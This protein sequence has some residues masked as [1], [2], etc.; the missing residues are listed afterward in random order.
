MKYLILGM[1][2][3]RNERRVLFVCQ[4]LVSYGLAVEIHSIYAGPK[5][6]DFYFAKVLQHHYAIYHLL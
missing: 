1:L 3:F 2:L 6:R 5:P 4:Q